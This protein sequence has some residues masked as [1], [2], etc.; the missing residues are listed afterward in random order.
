[1]NLHSGQ[2]WL[3]Y[4]KWISIPQHLISVLPDNKH[5]T[6]V[7]EYRLN[8]L[9]SEVLFNKAR[10]KKKEMDEFLVEEDPKS[11]NHPAHHCRNT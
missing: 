1:M 4:R 7:F 8:V 9:L 11:D 5:L 3:P 2:N 6:I 10:K